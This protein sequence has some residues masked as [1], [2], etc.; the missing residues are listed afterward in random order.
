ML[1]PS[2]NNNDVLYLVHFMGIGTI[3][4]GV[5]VMRMPIDHGV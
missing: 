3:D 2:I 4:H 1:A 5:N